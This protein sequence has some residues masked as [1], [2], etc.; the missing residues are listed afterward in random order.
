MTSSG[1]ASEKYTTKQKSDKW[2]KAWTQAKKNFPGDIQLQRKFVSDN[3][4]K[5]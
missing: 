3:W 2:K 4:E 1:G 5:Y